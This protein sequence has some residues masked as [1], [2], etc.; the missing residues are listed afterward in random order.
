MVTI[1]S[2][3]WRRVE[4]GYGGHSKKGISS[5]KNCMGWLNEP[6]QDQNF[7]CKGLITLSQISHTIIG[8]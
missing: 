7:S 4:K 3:E 5:S 8:E 6:N 2:V 1:V